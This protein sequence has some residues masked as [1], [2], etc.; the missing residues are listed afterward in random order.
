MRNGFVRLKH[1]E[2]VGWH[3]TG[4]NGEESI[5]LEGRGETLIEGEWAR[6][7]VSPRLVYLPPQTRHNVANTAEDLLE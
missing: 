4:K 2:S 1:G 5:T 3:T 6:A 7:C